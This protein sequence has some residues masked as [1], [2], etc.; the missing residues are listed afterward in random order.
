MTENQM[1]KSPSG[2]TWRTLAVVALWG[3]TTAAVA[4]LLSR[5]NLIAFAV[6]VLVIGIAQRV[7]AVRSVRRRGHDAPRWWQI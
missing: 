6:I 5:G 1:P 3:A 4:Y 2:P 7:L